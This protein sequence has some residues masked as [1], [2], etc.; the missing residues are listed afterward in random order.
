M[1]LPQE[2]ECICLVSYDPTVAIF[3]VTQSLPLIAENKQN[4]F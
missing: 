3:S 1:Q 4:Q 2:D